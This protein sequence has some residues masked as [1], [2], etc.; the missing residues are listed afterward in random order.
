MAPVP[1]V[2]LMRRPRSLVAHALLALMLLLGQIAAQTHAYNHLRLTGGDPATPTGQHTPCSECLSFAPLLSATHSSHGAADFQFEDVS[3]KVTVDS[4][5]L[6]S[7]STSHSFQSRA[8]P[9]LL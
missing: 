1:I 5:S 2:T 9:V 7:R 3:A 4:V 6:T 8:P